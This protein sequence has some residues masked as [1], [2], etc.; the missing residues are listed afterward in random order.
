MYRSMQSR[1]RSSGGCLYALSWLGRPRSSAPPSARR[2]TLSGSGAA[3]PRGSWQS[4]RAGCRP[5]RTTAE[6]RASMA[7]PP[8]RRCCCSSGAWTT[9]RA[10]MS[11]SRRSPSPALKVRLVVAGRGDPAYERHVR[12][13]ADE[14]GV[15]S[16]MYWAGWLG[17]QDKA[18]AYHAA[19]LFVL[20]SYNENY[21]ITVI[22]AAQAGLPILLTEDVYTSPELLRAGLARA[23]TREPRVAAT[24]LADLLHDREALDSM[25]AAARRFGESTS[26]TSRSGPP[27]RHC[28]TRP[29]QG[30]AAARKRVEPVGAA[31][32]QAGPSRP[33]PARRAV[34]LPT[35]ERRCSQAR[36]RHCADD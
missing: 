35:A 24:A 18:D 12:D 31:S 8:T 29:D 11:W 5:G 32:A 30:S 13:L 22:E 25:A 14:R 33:A 17:T 34:V 1:N 26:A 23:T 19:D 15:G 7:P 2:S 28:S 16:R 36:P 4:R 27:T 9:R 6:V 21:G 3:P 10:C 20:L